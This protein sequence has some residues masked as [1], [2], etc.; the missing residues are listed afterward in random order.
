MSDEGW[1]H[2]FKPIPRLRPQR[3]LHTPYA[4]NIFLSGLSGDEKR[5]DN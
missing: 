2:D 5:M 3:I 1:I 4:D